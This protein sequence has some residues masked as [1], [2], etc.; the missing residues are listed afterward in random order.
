MG[1][2]PAGNTTW[3]RLLYVIYTRGKRFKA[4]GSAVLAYSES[5][6]QPR[7]SI[8]TP[9]YKAADFLAT[10]V[11]SALN[12][13]E[14][15]FELIIVDDCSPDST[16]AV[17]ADLAAKD[18]RIRPIYLDQ[19]GGAA[20][21]LNR[22]TDAA[23]GRWVALLDADDWYA[24]DRLQRLLDAAEATNVA[25]VA[26]NQYM[27]DA[28]AGR[29][30][31]TAWPAS[32]G[33]RTL[34][35][36]DFLAATDPTAAF[37]LGMLKPV[38]RTDFIRDHNVVYREYSRHGYD[39]LVLLD[40]FVAG[41]QALLLD[42]PFYYYLQPYGTLSRQW[43]QAG[44]KRYPFEH[45]K[46]L[47]DRM[48]AELRSTLPG[49]QLAALERRGQAMEGL[50]RFFQVTEHVRAGKPVAAIK[51]AATAPG[52]FWKIAAHRGARFAARLGARP[53]VAK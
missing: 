7:V 9:A 49:A 43:A 15:S 37:D 25:M 29:T 51:A 41:G 21:A 35:L 44:R 19:N 34:G 42:E 26:D 16:R 5:A 24:T 11:R 47:N 45:V 28:K 20:H 22:A 10:A 3:L 39:Y 48:V 33:R 31:G 8:I 50:A 27:F 6:E 32:G 30:V 52:V 14:Q 12:Q 46:E 36:E 13:T 18:A 40:F 23:R 4:G 2:N 53:G 38:F 17:L 1:S